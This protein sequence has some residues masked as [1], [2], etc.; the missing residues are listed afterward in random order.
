MAQ[1]LTR[2]NATSRNHPADHPT[3]PGYAMPAGHELGRA[4]LEIM[5]GS[6]VAA[7][8]SL[9]AQWIISRLHASRPTFVPN[10]LIALGMSVLLAGSLLLVVWHRWPRWATPMSWA[11][12]SA[13]ATGPLSLA[14]MGT[15]YYMGG[16]SIDQTF[17][18]QYLTRLASSPAL[19][20]FTYKG[21]A[22]FYP[23]TWFWLGGRFANVMHLPA[24][25]AY[26]PWAILT[27]AVAGVVATALWALLVG[28]RTAFLLGML[29]VLIG[30]TDGVAEP[31]SWL[32][33]VTIPPL[34]VLAWRMLEGL[35]AP[36]PRR[37]A[38][39]AT[40]ML[41]VAIGIYGDLYTLYLAYFVLLLVVMAAVSVIIARRRA[42]R[43]DGEEPVPDVGRL[44]GRIAVRYVLG[45]LIGVGVMLPVWTPYL[46]ATLSG[47]R[48]SNVAARYLPQASAELPLPM[49]QFSA[50]GALSLLGLGWIVVTARRSVVARALAV[51]V[52][53]CYLWFLL[54]FALL[55]AGTTLLA[56]RLYSVL[57][58][59]LGCAGLLAGLD[60]LRAVSGW[61]S[62]RRGEFRTLAVVLAFA[63]LMSLVQAAPSV[64]QQDPH[65]FDDYYPTGV[66]AL[67]RSNP[68]DN[69]YW[70]PQLN[71]AIHDVT[72]RPPQDLVLLT[73]QT[74]LLTTSPYWSF[75]ALTPH[76]ADPLS[77]FNQRR[78]QIQSWAA[79]TGPEQLLTDLNHSA[80]AAPT[81]FVLLRSGNR[82][83]IQVAFTPSLFND[84]HF[85]RRDVGP[86]T[87]I[88]RH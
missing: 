43:Q 14:L 25:A 78:A 7:L 51:T 48:G 84:P 42:G 58:V 29:T 53:T 24:W 73:D 22:P 44:V 6:L 34:A 65:A 64:A 31:Y 82:L 70:V 26:K 68:S 27:L 62:A 61:L 20:D 10:D 46:V 74:L 55:A 16:L 66:N 15:R 13:A 50:L 54:S 72:G 76:Y 77:N 9:A 59:V 2:K 83:T 17:R 47:Q 41:G 18:T 75:Q 60:L 67:G 38:V 45:G 57:V 81:V 88:A 28:R 8:V 1:L 49:L 19:A 33:T 85:I 71:S 12:L 35:T 52:A 79:A 32:I 23:A 4:G 56:F 30:L 87:V 80:Y 3:A 5:L 69:N 21:I 36:T 40:V 11:V 86:Y 63:T 39:G 37:G